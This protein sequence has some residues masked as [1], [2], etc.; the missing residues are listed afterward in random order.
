M[1]GISLDEALDKFRK[2]IDSKQFIPTRIDIPINTGLHMIE[3]I[4]Q[5]FKP[6]FVIDDLNRSAF[7][8]LFW[9]FTGQFENF[10]GDPE[11]GILAVG[12]VGAGK[13]L[14]MVVMQHFLE[15]LEKSGHYVGIAFKPHYHIVKCNEIK[16]DFADQDIGGLKTLKPYKTRH[17]VYCFDDL[18]EEYN[19]KQPMAIHFGVQINVMENILT[20]RAELFKVHHTLTHCTS[21]YLIQSLD[22]SKKYFQD[23]YGKRVADRAAE[24]FNTIVF[25]GGSRRK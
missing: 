10:T 12:N 17:V 24:M 4:G 21:N 13:T 5:M 6:K 18:G 16:S 23:F 11:K 8:Q 15:F 7:E 3:R 2:S 25:E 19:A 22:G 1:D 14:A 20:S 9:Y